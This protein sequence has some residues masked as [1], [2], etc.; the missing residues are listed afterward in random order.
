[1]VCENCS[2]EHDGSYGSGRFCSPACSRS[3]STKTKRAEI[4]QK[5]KEKL[6][7]RVLSD[8]HKE[9]LRIGWQKTPVRK[10]NR[11]K[12]PISEI[13][14][15]NSKFHNIYIKRRLFEEGLK[16]NVCEDCGIENYNGKPLTMQI[17]HV[18]GNNKD[19]RLENLKMLCP[20]CHSQTENWSGR[21]RSLRCF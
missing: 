8:R 19:N 9:N 13:C 12:A 20:N 4:N 21:N 7:G 18:N 11:E 15:L 14:V 6:T 17:H 1:M 10:W 16:K 2:A 3:Y 5:V